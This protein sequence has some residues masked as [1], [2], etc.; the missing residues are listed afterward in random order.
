VVG[1]C[2]VFDGVWAKGQRYPVWMSHGDRVTALP[3]GFT[4]IGVSGNAPFA[5]VADEA[6]K[7]YG[8]QFHPEVMHTPDGAKL[9][10]NFVHKV[11]GLK[12]DWT[13]R[14]F[15][16]REIERIRAQVGKGRVLLGLSGGVDSSVVAL[17][18]HEAIGDQLT[19]V[20]VDTGLLRKDEAKQVVD[21]FRHHYNIALVHRNAA[22]L[23]LERLAG[24][25]DPEQKLKIIGATFIE[26]FDEEAAKVG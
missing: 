23:F 26:V 17:L 4:P 19:C 14:A 15:R 7:F 22:K 11:A 12:G 1:D 9:L 20:F 2:A 24:V 5:A 25:T 16:T 10:A 6:R 8:F 21:L 18:L 13:M 3:K